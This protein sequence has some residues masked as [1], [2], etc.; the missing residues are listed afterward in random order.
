M[1]KAVQLTAY[2]GVDQLNI[3]D[4]A[5]PEPAP[6]EVV[7]RVV[8]AGINPGEISIREGLLKDRWPMDFPFG[9]GTDFAG[10]VDAVGA[11]VSGFA[12][13][14][15]VLG[16]T[17]RRSAHAEYVAA[18]AKQLV[19]KPPTLDWY[20][21]GSLFVV[22]ATAFAAVRAVALKPGD[23]VAISGAAGGVGSLAT[24][25]A[26]RTGARVLGI[27]S[28]ESAD[29]LR[30]VGV[31]PVAYGD[32]LADFLRERVP[33]GINAFIDL[34]GGGYIELAVSLGVAVDRIDTITDFAAAQK[35]GTKTDGSGAASTRETLAGVA[36]LIAW[37]E[38]VMPLTAI[39]PFAAL[40]DAYTELA[41]RKARGKIVLAL[42]PAITEPIRPPA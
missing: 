27:A 33:A 28:P 30:S 34:F 36:N 13:G 25:L 2:G 32:G 14:D 3:V 5:K 12:P 38:I 24:Q 9:E 17:E 40:R 18:P 26:R 16:W 21:A 1:P 41:R 10:H 20:R 42:D 11:N 29:F 8:A 15:E 23:V 35:F 22:A 31:E 37:G 4:V 39:Y 7:V 6:G 19:P